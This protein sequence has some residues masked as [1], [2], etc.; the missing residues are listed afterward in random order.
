[1]HRLFVALRP[2]SEMRDTLLAA[3]G[4]IEN[5]RWQSAEQLHCTLRFIGD[6]DRPVAEDVEAALGSVRF[7]GLDLALSGVGAFGADG[8]RKAVWA[9][10]S[11]H[12]Q[13]TKLH[14]KIDQALVRAGLAPER[15]AYLPHIT[16]ARLNRSSGAIDRF[17]AD[18]ARLASPPYR[19]THFLLFRSTLGSDGAT[20][21]AIARYALEPAA[22]AG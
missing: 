17:L 16:L 9:G 15:R 11:P 12:D 6:V 4:G 10:V 1:M 5:A 14:K 3:M 20:Y 2:P 21:E 13:I 7:P 18:Q 8:R 19:F 22:A